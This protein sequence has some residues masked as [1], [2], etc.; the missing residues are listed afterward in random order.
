MNGAAVRFQTFSARRVAT[1]GHVYCFQW[2]RDFSYLP[3]VQ[4]PRPTRNEVKDMGTA[5]VHR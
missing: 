2:D 1:C 5:F 4:Q 3:R